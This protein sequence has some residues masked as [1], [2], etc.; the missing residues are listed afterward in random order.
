MRTLSWET[1]P[2]IERRVRTPGTAVD[3][4]PLVV[5]DLRK[6]EFIDSTGLGVLVKTHQQMRQANRR[7]VL[8]DGEGQVRRLLAMTGLSDQL[9]VVTAPIRRWTAAE[10]GRAEPSAGA[11]TGHTRHGSAVFPLTHGSAA[12][13]AVHQFQVNQ[14]SVVQRLGAEQVDDT[15]H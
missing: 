8:V 14:F 12:A 9:I 7:L 2:I 11:G 13:A 3:G 4:S 15:G 1:G 6:L 10:Q 5:I